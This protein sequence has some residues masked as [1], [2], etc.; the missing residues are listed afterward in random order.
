MGSSHTTVFKRIVCVTAGV[1]AVCLFVEGVAVPFAK[2][3]AIA[4]QRDESVKPSNVNRDIGH[5]APPKSSAASSGGVASAPILPGRVD[6]VDHDIR[7]NRYISFNPNNTVTPVAL[8]V[9]M[10]DLG[11][12][13]T[14]EFCV[15]DF[16]CKTCVGG[17]D[18]G[19]A[20]HIDSD[21]DGG[22]VCTVSGET[23][24]EL[25]P[26]RRLGWVSDPFQPG[27]DALPGT[28]G[29]TIVPTAPAFRAWPELVVHIG[30]CP[31]APVRAYGFRATTD[32]INFSDRLRV[33]TIFKPQRGEWADIVG[34]WNGNEWTAPDSLNNAHDLTAWIN[35]FT[36][37]PAPH[38]TVGDLVGPVPNWIVSVADRY[39][40][41]WR[42]FSS[43]FP[44]SDFLGSGYPDL[45]NG[46]SLCDCPNVGCPPVECGNGILEFGERCD[47]GN[48]LGGDGCDES[49]RVETVCGNGV[50][51]NIE[52]CDDGNTD[53]GDGCDGAC[54]I[55]PG[56]GNGFI[57]GDEKCDDG[58]TTPGDGCDELCRIE[59]E[60]GNGTREFTEQCDDGNT[61]PGDGC[62]ATC[63]REGPVVLEWV[64]VSSTVA[65][66]IS[67]NDIV[68]YGTGGGLVEFEA[69][70]SD[71]SLAPGSPSL[72]AV[73]FALEPMGLQGV[74]ALPAMPGFDLT[75]S[76]SVPC[77]R[78]SDCQTGLCGSFG[79][80]ACDDNEPAFIRRNACLDDPS[81]PCS[82]GSDCDGTQVCLANPAFLD[83]S[84]GADASLAPVL[85]FEWWIG[86]AFSSVVDDGS[87]RYVGSLR[88]NVPPGVS[89]S[90]V[91]D[92]DHRPEKT[93]LLNQDNLII[94]GLSLVPA[95]ITFA[96]PLA[97]PG[98]VD[99]VDHD[100]LKNR[101]VSFSPQLGT[102]SARLRV[103]LLDLA[104]GSTGKKCSGDAD[105]RICDFGPDAGNGCTIN[106]DCAGGSCVVSGESCSEQS[107]PLLLGY[108]S[109]PIQAGGDAGPGTLRSA[110]LDD[111]PAFRSWLETLVHIADCEI[112]P[113]Q[114]YGIIVETAQIPG[115]FSDPLVIGTTPK[116]QDKSWGDLVGSFDGTTW[117]APDNLV[118]VNDV[119]AM[120][121]F[122]TLK[123]APHITVIDM[124]GGKPTFFNFDLNVRDLQILLKAFKGD[125]FPPQTILADDYPDLTNGASLAD[126]TGN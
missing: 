74:N 7:K 12:S 81:E 115:V 117:S 92:F 27:G 26:A 87:R 34:P 43:P 88:I 73:N 110:V 89:S 123:P 64:P 48:V 56:C 112:A 22:G 97:L 19:D 126:C 91:I 32:L 28:H 118:G 16:D 125:A 106:S 57:S 42:L 90:Y 41:N 63:R 98:V 124:V 116:P 103:E 72:N 119:Q 1:A 121:K 6:G 62:G 2:A 52:E 24:D 94:D 38:V 59:T 10:L 84:C 15:E 104:C 55:E 69:F 23:C 65:A 80:L 29:A 37:K 85:P 79:T 76:N 31:I 114:T 9:E 20:C 71:W 120:I 14:H 49:C 67:G 86:C 36:N 66:S 13:S 102:T 61:D 21:C 60:C 107:P 40:W 54:A 44:P 5:A 30:D 51:E 82:N 100:I 109:E 4:Q 3:Q 75:E 18:N 101:V 39:P 113:D 111:P 78:D 45:N 70:L 8:M 108:V 68:L 33:G 35:F 50:V 58:N 122:I 17:G 83:S 96:K 95:R 11:C 93:F 25:A 105:C 77:S 99:G 46:G 47:D 53:A